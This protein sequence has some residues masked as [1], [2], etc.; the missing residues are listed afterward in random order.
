MGFLAVSLV[1]KEHKTQRT[2]EDIFPFG[3]NFLREPGP[4]DLALGCHGALCHRSPLSH[5]HRILRMTWSRESLR[6]MKSQDVCRNKWGRAGKQE[7]TEEALRM[8]P[9]WYE[10]LVC[11]FLS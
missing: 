3:V 11:S 5:A 6:H 7:L 10:E 2:S 4:T 8:G 1:V 9:D